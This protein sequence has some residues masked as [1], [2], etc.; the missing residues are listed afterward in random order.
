MG[1]DVCATA[2]LLSVLLLDR[3]EI[4]QGRQEIPDPSV[5]E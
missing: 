3:Q 2:A 1:G 5:I 4:L